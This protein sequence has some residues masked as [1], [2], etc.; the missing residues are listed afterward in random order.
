MMLLAHAVWMDRYVDDVASIQRGSF[1]WDH[2][3]HKAEDSHERRNFLPVDGRCFGYCAR[4]RRQPDESYKAHRIDIRRLGAAPR[5]DRAGPADVVWTA[6]GPVDGKRVVIGWYRKATVFRDLQPTSAGLEGHYFSAAASDCALLRPVHRT[7]EIVRSNE[8]GKGH[9]PGHD[10]IFFVSEKAPSLEARL[11]KYMADVPADHSFPLVQ[12]VPSAGSVK[13]Q[14]DPLKRQLVEQAAVS[15]VRDALGETWHLEDVSDQNCG[16]DLTARRNGATLLIEIKGLSGSTATV[17][18]TFNEYATMRASGPPKEDGRFILAIVTDA[19][20]D[21]RQVRAF[22]LEDRWH[23]FDLRTGCVI[24][25]SSL[26]LKIVP[27][28]AARVSII[29]AT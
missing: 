10:A 2:V 29:E 20:T 25:A 5:A 3:N 14:V 1:N 26:A 23:G 28:T 17:E 4:G 21:Q 13:R 7:F 6:K 11:R 12:P 15:A 9:G 19:L 16:W 27:V 8:A 24:A 22:G 18:L